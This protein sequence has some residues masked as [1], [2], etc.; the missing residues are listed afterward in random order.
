MFVV[1]KPGPFFCNNILNGVIA[2]TLLKVRL[3]E[4]SGNTLQYS[5]STGTDQE[6]PDNE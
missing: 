6:Q 1:L 2:E 5:T 4:Y 3:Q